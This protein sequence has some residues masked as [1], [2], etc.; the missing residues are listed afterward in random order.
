M[1]LNI[2]L[3]PYSFDLLC[4]NSFSKWIKFEYGGS[5]FMSLYI[6]ATYQL[7]LYLLHIYYIY[8]IHKHTYW[9]NIYTYLLNIYKHIYIYIYIYMYII[10][11][12]IYIY[13]FSKWIKFA[14]G[15][16]MRT[17]LY[18]HSW[19]Y[20]PVLRWCRTQISTEQKTLQRYCN[21]TRIMNVNWP[22]IPEGMHYV[23]K[24]INKGKMRTYFWIV[25]FFH[26]SARSSTFLTV[27]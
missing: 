15:G 1:H 6:L 17:W 11:C 23:Q 8:Y 13:N 2:G 10:I 7:S 18:I 16:N 14:Y 12:C 26:F 22:F 27:C 21:S 9:Y 3:N 5:M 4:S 25:D 19:L 20:M 24:N